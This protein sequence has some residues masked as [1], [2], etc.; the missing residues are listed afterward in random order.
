MAIVQSPRGVPAKWSISTSGH[1]NLV[2]LSIEGCPAA[3]PFDCSREP[4]AA[5]LRLLNSAAAELSDEPLAT[6]LEAFL[7][8]EHLGRTEALRAALLAAGVA[9]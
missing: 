1:D 5:I 4:D 3:R 7:K 2:L 9:A 6:A 8:H